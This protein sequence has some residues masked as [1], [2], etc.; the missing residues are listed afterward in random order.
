ML[1]PSVPERLVFA[2]GKLIYDT[3]VQPLPMH[4]GY[5]A[6]EDV[7]RRMFEKRKRIE[8]S[9]T[10]IRT[11]KL[12]D[13][14]AGNRLTIDCGNDRIDIGRTLTEV[15]REWLFQEIRREYGA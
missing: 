2:V 11:L 1:Q 3:G 6:R 5:R 8:F 7:W 15:E 10:E 14:D 9:P 12:R 4:F 13:T